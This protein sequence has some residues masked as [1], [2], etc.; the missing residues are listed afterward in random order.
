MLEQDQHAVLGR[1]Q[2]QLGEGCDDLVEHGEL[3]APERVS[4]LA[5]Q[6]ANAVAVVGRGTGSSIGIGLRAHL[7]PE[8]APSIRSSA[9]YG[10]GAAP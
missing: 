6:R 8:S 2:L 9:L 1:P 7:P 3:R 5:R 10:A 4:D